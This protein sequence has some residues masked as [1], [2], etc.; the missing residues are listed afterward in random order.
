MAIWQYKFYV[1]PNSN[2]NIIKTKQFGKD[3]DNC[4]DDSIFWN[5]K[6]ISIEFFK[7]VDEILT[8]TKSWS[9]DLI[10]YGNL[11]TNCL[12]IL[13]V[14]NFIKSVSLR[15]DFSNE[16]QS[17]LIKLLSFLKLKDL[18]LLDENLEELPLNY[19]SI[20]TIIN[21]SQ[22]FKKYHDLSNL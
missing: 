8:M 9:K 20:K 15:I 1:I 11:E 19:L 4:F 12:E 18:I 13:C 21:N 7:K 6:E 22:Q 10:I 3:I 14:N 2:Q 17:I 16:Y 5:G